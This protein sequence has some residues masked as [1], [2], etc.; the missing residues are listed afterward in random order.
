MTP[1]WVYVLPHPGQPQFS[2]VG[3]TGDLKNRLRGYQTA[4]PERNF[5]FAHTW[6]LDTIEEARLLES[7]VLAAAKE[8]WPV[9]NEWVRIPA[10]ILASL[11]EGFLL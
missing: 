10:S 1:A 2:K 3:I 7:E 9:K 4:S 5:S 11:V 8:V 6:E